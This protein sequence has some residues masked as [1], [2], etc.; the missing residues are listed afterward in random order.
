VADEVEAL[1]VSERRQCR[2]WPLEID[3][4]EPQ[5]RS[6]LG[7][8]YRANEI[9][10]LLNWREDLLGVREEHLAQRRVQVT[11]SAPGDLRARR[12][13]TAESVRDRRL[14]TTALGA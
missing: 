9:V 4:R 10:G 2:T 12:A 8:A 13:S 3:R 7:A 6:G 5:D 1:E 11:A 14:S